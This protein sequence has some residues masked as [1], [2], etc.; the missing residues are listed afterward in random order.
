M[1]RRRK[2]HEPS[3][4][5]L[6]FCPQARRVDAH[7]IVVNKIKVLLVSSIKITSPDRD[8]RDRLRDVRWSHSPVELKPPGAGRLG[9]PWLRCFVVFWLVGLCVRVLALRAKAVVLHRHRSNIPCRLTHEV[10]DTAS[11]VL[12]PLS[13][14]P[15]FNYFR[16]CIWLAA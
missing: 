15:S 14:L 4:Q 8:D 9:G 5:K 11:S 7:R 10:L 13:P 6:T 16:S 3:L 1:K 2:K 12:L